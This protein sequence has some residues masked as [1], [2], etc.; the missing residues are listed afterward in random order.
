[1][2]RTKQQRMERKKERAEMRKRFFDPSDFQPKESKYKILS[3]EPK[4]MLEVLKILEI[5]CED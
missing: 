2:R 4:R 1:M 3:K 5:L